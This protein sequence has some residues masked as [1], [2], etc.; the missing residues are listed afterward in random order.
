MEGF[1]LDDCRAL[2]ELALVLEHEPLIDLFAQTLVL[3]L[4]SYLLANE[5]LDVVLISLDVSQLLQ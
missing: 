1:I 3:F 2:L 4:H 5:E